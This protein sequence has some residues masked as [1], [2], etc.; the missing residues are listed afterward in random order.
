MFVIGS[1]CRQYA[2]I[3]VTYNNIWS[4][5]QEKTDNK[6]TPPQPS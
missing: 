1:C 2:A 4:N 6:K 5:K 3:T